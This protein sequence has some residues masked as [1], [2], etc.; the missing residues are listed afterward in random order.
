MVLE[1]RYEPAPSMMLD[2]HW[3]SD[4]SR[5]AA[6]T[7][8]SEQSLEGCGQSEAGQGNEQQDAVNDDDGIT[9]E[10]WIKATASYTSQLPVT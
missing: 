9:H 10:F 1:M 8:A 7:S 2:W 3:P 5:N 6:R 4:T